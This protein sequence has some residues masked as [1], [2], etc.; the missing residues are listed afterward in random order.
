M[1]WMTVATVRSRER[2]TQLI[3]F[4]LAAG[5]S[6]LLGI[7]VSLRPL[8]GLAALALLL[9]AVLLFLLVAAS[10]TRPASA[11]ISVFCFLAVVGLLRR[12]A[13]TTMESLQVDPLLLVAPA[14]AFALIFRTR[15]QPILAGGDAISVLGLILVAVGVVEVLNPLGGGVVPGSVGFLYSVFPL[16]WFW[17]GSV[18]GTR[19]VIQRLGWVLVILATCVA[20]YGLY[21]I[22]VA[23][24]PWDAAWLTSH[25]SDY[26]ALVAGGA[27]RAFGTFASSAEFATFLGVGVTF[28]IA[29]VNRRRIYL[30]IPCVL[31]VVAQFLDASRGVFVLT[32]VAAVLVI[33][34]RS[35]HPSTAIAIGVIVAMAGVVISLLSASINSAATQSANPFVIHQVAGLL[36]PVDPSQSTL[37]AH[38][39][40]VTQSI[41]SVLQAPFGYGP[42]ATNIAGS[43][44][45]TLN[46]SS[47]FDISNEF[48]N[49][50]LVGGVTYG[51]IVA[52]AM[53]RAMI[54]A[55]RDPLPEHIWIMAVMVVNLGQWLN[56]GYYLLAPLTWFLI[57]GMTRSW[58]ARR[59]ARQ[60]ETASPSSPLSLSPST[61]R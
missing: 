18:L 14:M 48:V 5:L 54:L 15:P 36:N 1:T 25:L 32:L 4:G 53:A 11:V 61:H 29:S 49:L 47:E 40:L 52:I 26:H 19:G 60:R 37:L 28:V 23:F 59:S 55:W 38:L 16:V 10:Q 46:L 34:F 45:A 30:L 58:L 13:P 51:A 35:R 50:G 31:L 20:I 41:G 42:D 3:E 33:A 21:Q 39:N 44:F 43:R 2:I 24:P 56:G 6:M 17:I 12:V 27:V 8:G 7:E 22:Q 9:S 57:G